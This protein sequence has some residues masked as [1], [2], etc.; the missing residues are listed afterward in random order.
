MQ[1]DDPVRLSY[2]YE[3]LLGHTSFRGKTIGSRDL[4]VAGVVPYVCRC[5]KL[6]RP[7]CSWTHPHRVAMG[8]LMSDGTVNNLIRYKKI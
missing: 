3:D 1:R 6:A 5:L 2:W 8:E 7:N 4:G